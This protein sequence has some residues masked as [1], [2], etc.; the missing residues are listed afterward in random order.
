[1]N[2]DEQEVKF[3]EAFN[4]RKGH[5]EQVDDVLVV[6]FYFDRYINLLIKYLKFIYIYTAR[7]AVYFH[8][9]MGV[10]IWQVRISAYLRIPI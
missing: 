3:L 5:L 10:S 6:V 7:R 9:F 1:M 4:S 8:C 2:T